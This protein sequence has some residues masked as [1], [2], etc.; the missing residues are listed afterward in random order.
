MCNK[1]LKIHQKK[2]ERQRVFT[3]LCGHNMDRMEERKATIYSK[4]KGKKKSQNK[5]N[6]KGWKNYK[7]NV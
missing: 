7:V 4:K 2:E 6:M 5:R 1:E 3:C